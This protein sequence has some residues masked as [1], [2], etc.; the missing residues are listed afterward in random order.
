MPSNHGP[1]VC[2]W[3]I[4]SFRCAAILRRLSKHSGLGSPSNG[5]RGDL[6][7][8]QPAKLPLVINLQTARMLGLTILPALLARADELIE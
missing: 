2:T 6:P 8:Q 3:H 4:A 7:V 1:E 5:T